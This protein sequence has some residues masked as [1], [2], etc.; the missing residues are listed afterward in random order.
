MTRHDSADDETLLLN[1]IQEFYIVR[2][3]LVNRKVPLFEEEL[4]RFLESKL[5][6]CTKGS[7]GVVGARWISG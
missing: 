3:G 2:A 7:C 6:K 5:G 4:K 1:L